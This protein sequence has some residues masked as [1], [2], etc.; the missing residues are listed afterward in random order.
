MDP[1]FRCGGVIKHLMKSRSPDD[2]SPNV[3]YHQFFDLLSTSLQFFTLVFQSHV[4][5]STSNA[6]PAGQRT[7]ANRLIAFKFSPELSHLSF[8]SDFFFVYFVCLK[9]LH[10]RSGRVKTIEGKFWVKEKRGGFRKS[11][12]SRHVSESQKLLI[13]HE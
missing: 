9:N 7:F 4:C 13:C 10:T 12:K 1:K 8:R 6:K 2:E 11:L 3:I 5:R